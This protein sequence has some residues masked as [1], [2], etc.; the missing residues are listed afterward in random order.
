MLATLLAPDDPPSAARAGLRRALAEL[1]GVVRPWLATSG[2]RIA[3]RRDAAFSL[4]VD[5]LLAA[6]AARSAAQPG[7][8]LR[9]VAALYRG[10]FMAGFSLA[11]SANFE[12]WQFFQAERLRAV[13]AD[14][15]DRLT[16]QADTPEGAAQGIED[17]R[18]P[19][20]RSRPSPVRRSRSRHSPS[21]GVRRS[22]R[23]SPPPSPTRHAASSP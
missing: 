2:D 18:R 10:D 3:L 22:S 16:A 17:A 12:E 23:A 11:G 5:Q 14:L 13:Y 19:V 20:C 7:A 6:D 21:S 15:L 8:D 1:R 9:A 4:D